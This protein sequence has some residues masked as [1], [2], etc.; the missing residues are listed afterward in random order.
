MV[1]VNKNLEKM[2]VEIKWN[3]FFHSE[4][5]IPKKIKNIESNI[6]KS[7]ISYY[8]YRKFLLEDL[9]KITKS[10]FGFILGWAIENA[11]L[12]G[13]KN[14]P[15]LPVIINYYLGR[16]GIVSRIKDFGEGFNYMEVQEK[17]L[18]REKY[19]INNGAGFAGYNREDVEVNF[20]EA[21]SIINLMY[22]CKIEEDLKIFK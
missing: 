15:E 7:V 20:E 17:Y 11:L 22:K 13:N 14:N 4:I 5:I 19:F 9:R 21:G 10:D 3:G 12:R 16:E 1:I 18:K 8:N 2:L 6:W